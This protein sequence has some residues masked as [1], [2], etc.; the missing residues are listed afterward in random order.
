MSFLKKVYKASGFGMVSDP[1]RSMAKGQL[2]GLLGLGGGD[3]GAKQ[4]AAL[5]GA[6]GE[7]KTQTGISTERAVGSTRAA[8][9]LVMRANNKARQGIASQ[10]EFSK[11][12]LAEQMPGM[13]AGGAMGLVGTGMDSSSLAPLVSRAA[14]ANLSRSYSNIDRSVADQMTSLGVNEGNQVAGL[15][16]QG[17]QMVM[18]GQGMQNDLTAQLAQ[19]ISN[20]R[21]KR[22]K[23]LF[24][25]IGAVAPIVG[26]ALGGPAGAMAGSAVANGYGNTGEGDDGGA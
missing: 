9:P 1:L 10:A 11:R 17:G 22:K 15:M 23:N 18:Q 3:P 19:A 20:Q 14:Q 12:R 21:F 25:L 6:I 13:L 7:G 8:I 26:G 2:N 4:M 24:D 16:G 5:L